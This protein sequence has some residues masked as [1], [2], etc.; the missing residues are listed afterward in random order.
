MRLDGKVALLTGASEG[1]G[2]A[3]AI[4]LRQRGARLSLVAR[5]HEKLAAIAASEDVVTAADLLDS[6][7]RRTAVQRTIDQFGRIDILI[8]NAGAG[9]YAPSHSTPMDQV[10]K[11]WELNFF[12]PLELIQLA[13]PY[14]KQKKDGVIVNVGSIAGKVTLPWFTVYSASKY[15]LGSLTDGLRMELASDGIH[16]MIVCPGYVQTRFQQNVLA[17]QPPVLTGLRQRWA[18]TPERCAEDIARGIERR[19]RTVVTPGTAWLLVALARLF[20][21]QVDQ[22]LT[23]TYLQQMGMPQ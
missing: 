9:L 23:K 21:G 14:M 15:A 16:T 2:A 3:L 6:A 7:N 12:A 20:P 18:I 4:V 8:N 5:N 17:G 22:Q 1:I 10:R 13:V 19:K 11:L